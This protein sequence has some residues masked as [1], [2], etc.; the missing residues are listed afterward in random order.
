MITVWASAAWLLGL[1]VASLA[2]LNLWQWF[3]LALGALCSCFIFKQT[4]RFRSVFALLAVLFLAGA[5]WELAKPTI[6]QDHV[7]FYADSGYEVQS[8]GQ[9][10]EDPDVRES[11]TQ[12]E[13]SVE[14]IWIPTLEIHK[15]VEGS[16]L[17]QASP[18]GSYKY[19]QRLKV[20]GHLEQP[21]DEGDFSY[22]AYLARQ[23]I[24]AWMPEV[25]IRSLG[26]GKVNPLLGILHRTRQL[27][28][29]EIQR[30]F[31]YP[32]APLLS[33]ILLGI[34][35]RIPED[36]RQAYS[37]TG[38]THIIAISGFNI[39]ILA[40]LTIAVFGRYLGRTR[41]LIVA[42]LIIA[43]YTLFVGAD[44][45]VVRAAIMGT[46]ALLARQLGRRTHGLTSLAVASMT[47]TILAPQSVQDVGFQLSFAA[48][49]G[50]I[51][52][53]EPLKHAAIYL[54]RRLSPSIDPRQWGNALAE[55]TLF[56]LAAQLTTLPIIMWHFH[57]I[58]LVSLIAN[59]FILPLQPLLMILS[60]I[61]TIVGLIWHPLGQLIAYLAWPFS[62]LT[63]QL[64]VYLAETP[65][66]V[67][68][69]GTVKISWL[70]TYYTALFTLTA[71][72]GSSW[73]QKF[74]DITQS[75]FA[76]RRTILST[77]CLAL[78]SLSALT[79][80]HSISRQPDG[81][82][83]LFV[84][85]VGDGEALLLRTPS[86][87]AVLINGGSSPVALATELSRYLPYPNRRIDWLLLA[88]TQ[89]N[90][91]GGLRDITT[92]AT[93]ETALIS[94]QTDGSA[95]RTV[96]D[97]LHETGIPVYEAELGVQLDLAEGTTLE[98]LT[99]GSHGV[100][101]LLEY[102]LARFLLPIG[103]S[104]REIPDLLTNQQNTNVT[105]VLLGASGYQPVNTANLL[106]HL[107][108]QLILISCEAGACP[109]Q[110]DE[111]DHEHWTTHTI[112]STGKH[113]SIELVTDGQMLWITTEHEPGSTLSG[114][115]KEPSPVTK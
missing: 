85:D 41:G 62:A 33:G 59:A 38:T 5:R 97:Q 12:L 63:N 76:A 89:Y 40:G 43:L 48:T 90:Q 106:E 100:T 10:R 18:L 115:L 99:R 4:H 39:T 20:T 9:I 50:L 1:I 15:S 102:G 24:Y 70:L 96:L 25:S 108:P 35:S 8:T 105:A 54:I 79:V 83:H 67:I 110:K 60:G 84:L 91:L 98:V 64:V 37:A 19:G 28:L 81:H 2:P 57:Q 55:I 68:H 16:L 27:A 87:R 52:Y 82:L 112:L 95:Y 6:D 109:S 31:P 53:A 73:Q 114:D 71:F 42:G 101:L 77:G 47:M 56:T 58:S 49:L 11:R 65:G 66:G 34:E 86:G 80:W 46:L 61:A 104:P 74:T 45:P 93:V 72:W 30:I 17:V 94:G 13:L 29:L 21:P 22:R 44:A 32:E 103:L 78:L 26:M 69:T 14:Q 111:A 7:A 23:G 88:G 36:L 92:M 75:L 113:G 51:L 107:N 3:S